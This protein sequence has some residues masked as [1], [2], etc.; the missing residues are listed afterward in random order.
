MRYQLR[1]GTDDVP[2]F[3]ETLKDPEQRRYLTLGEIIGAMRFL[4]KNDKF[5]RRLDP[6]V[7][8]LVIQ[9]ENDQVLSPQSAKKVFDAA[10]TSDK[11]FILV[12]GCGHVLLGMSRLKPIV[13][14]SIRTFLNEMIL[15]H[16]VASKF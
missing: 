9:G 7:A 15:R 5:A 8:V 11:R 6:H 3:E 12:P 13:N 2:A 10:N 14:D 4:R 16:A 1:Y